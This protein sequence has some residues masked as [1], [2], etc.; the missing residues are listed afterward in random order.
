MDVGK[1]EFARLVG[2]LWRRWLA[3]NGQAPLATEEMA[4]LAGRLWALVVERGLPPPLAAGEDGAPGGLTEAECAPLVARVA[5]GLPGAHVADGVRQLVK[6]CFYPEF[7]NCR[8]SFRETGSDGACRRQ[9]L[10]RVRGRISGSHCVDCPHWV[11]LA[12]PEHERFLAAEWKSGSP[13]AGPAPSTG[14]GQAEA[15]LAHRDIFLPEDFRALRQWLHT[16]AR[17]PRR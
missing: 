3:Q 10:G 15:F 8:N 1:P 7:R 9:Q 16:R 13:G 17:S 12:A 6:T 2:N 14:S 5:G 11:S 4:G